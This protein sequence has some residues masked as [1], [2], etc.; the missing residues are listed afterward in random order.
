[1]YV[2]DRKRVAT[3]ATASSLDA[4]LQDLDLRIA[5][6]GLGDSNASRTL[7]LFQRTNQMNMSTRR[8]TRA[9]LDEWLSDDRRRLWTFSVADRFGEYGLCGIA[10]VDASGGQPVLS[11]FLVSCR[12]MGRGVEESMF[13]VAADYARS[14][15]QTTFRTSFVR[16]AKNGPCERWLRERPSARVDDGQFI[17]DVDA[18]VSPPQHVRL[19]FDA[20]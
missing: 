2:A 10:S 3:R 5:V 20:D 14:L 19:I 7:Q 11:D 13:A 9:Q 8:L 4:W 17:V 18:V 16:T 6:H 15:G 1:M 12:V